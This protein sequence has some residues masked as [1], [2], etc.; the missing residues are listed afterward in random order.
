MIGVSLHAEV[1]DLADICTALN[2]HA[3]RVHVFDRLMGSLL[4]EGSVE[5][6]R[7]LLPRSAVS[8][9]VVG[10]T[11]AQCRAAFDGQ[12]RIENPVLELEAARLRELKGKLEAQVA[13]T[14]ALLAR[15]AESLRRMA[16]QLTTAEHRERTRLADLIHDQLQQLLVAARMRINRL[17][18]EQ[19]AAE[20]AA[21]AAEAKQL[22]Q[23]AI[24]LGRSLTTELWPPVLY[25][26]GLAAAIQWLAQHTKFQHDID[27]ATCFEPSAEPA[28]EDMKAFLYQAVRELI[29]NAVKHARTRE[30]RVI[31]TVRKP[32]TLH[33]SVEDE[34]AGFDP[35]GLKQKQT[36]NGSLGL[37]TIQERLAAFGGAMRIE[38]S[39]GAGARIH[40]ELP[41]TRAARHDPEKALTR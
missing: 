11:P 22:I 31:A 38:S 5:E 13:A 25:Q 16:I 37:F 30:V 19:S 2:G 28:E 23:Q 7:T 4:F 12:W 32:N 40:M 34:G 27:V 17:G 18:G 20:H 8:I 39:R 26:S 14:M 41:L 10:A 3:G 24:E 33:I 1:N 9:D 29:F 21:S 36:A 6:V 15:Q 35:A